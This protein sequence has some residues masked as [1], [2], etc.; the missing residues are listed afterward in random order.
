MEIRGVIGIF[1]YTKC[2]RIIDFYDKSFDNIPVPK[3]LGRR[4]IILRKTV[5]FEG[6]CDLCAGK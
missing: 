2:K 3:S 1:K 5:Y 4:L 6:I